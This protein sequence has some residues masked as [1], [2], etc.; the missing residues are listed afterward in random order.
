MA[1]YA[2]SD[3]HGQKELWNQIKEYLKPEDTL[4]CLGDCV[5]RGPDGFDIL[6]EILNR[7]NTEM[8]MGNHEK[9]MLDYY[10]PGLEI[11]SF[12][13]Y[14]N[15]WFMNGGHYTFLNM[16]A[17]TGNQIHKVLKQVKQLNY[18]KIIYNNKGQKLIL[19]HSGYFIRLGQD[20]PMWNR[21]HFHESWPIEKEYENTY[22]IHGHTPTV[23]LFRFVVNGIEQYDKAT[24]QRNP[25]II[26]YADNHK[27][28]IDL[29][30]FATDKTCLLD[31]NTL[32]PIY[33]EQETES[34][35][36]YYYG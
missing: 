33:F 35:I 32:E 17:Y 25:E 36:E 11:N 12:T 7:P 6:I 13:M 8:I 3:L 1:I 34:D 27:I 16:Q 26:R 29:G 30:C 5:D 23:A 18:Q 9:L 4:Y 21:Y 19:D 20:D 10:R 28:D 31:L 24:I 15:L 2:V 14:D 22:M